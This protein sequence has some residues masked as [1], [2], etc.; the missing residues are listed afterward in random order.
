MQDGHFAELK[1]AELL[2]EKIDQLGAIESYIGTFFSKS[3]VNKNVLRMTD[4]EMEEMRKEINTEAGIE[5]EDGGVN[6]EPN[7]GINNEPLKGPE[8]DDEIGDDD[9][10]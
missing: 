3:W 5:P 10:Q 1:A 8:E 7:S 6:L 2:R 4:Y 9:E